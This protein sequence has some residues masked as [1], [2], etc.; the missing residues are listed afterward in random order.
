MSSRKCVHILQGH[1]KDITVLVVLVNGM[2]ASGSLDGTIKV[3]DVR[4]GRHRTLQVKSEVC[5]LAVLPSG[6][7][8]S[9][10]KDLTIWDLS[11]F[12]CVHTLHPA[13]DVRALTVLSNGHLASGHQHCIIR[14]WNMYTM[15]CIRTLKCPNPVLSLVVL[16]NQHLLAVCYNMDYDTPG[17]SCVWNMHTFQREKNSVKL[18][19]DVVVMPNG[20]VAECHASGVCVWQMPSS[21][22]AAQGQHEAQ[23]LCALKYCASTRSN[24]VEQLIDAALH[25]K[26]QLVLDYLHQHGI[27][28]LY[29]HIVTRL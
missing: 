24:A 21:Q 2:L 3:W 22:L 28:A 12:Q 7:L 6:H 5:A 4:S 13:D 18:R 29:T 20:C 14:V 25:I 15:Q 17:G 8:A 1:T 19:G 23:L 26:S 27:V 9:A 16:P 11:T 10:S